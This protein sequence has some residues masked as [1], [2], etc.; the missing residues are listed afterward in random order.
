MILLLL[1][2]SFSFFT[3]RQLWETLCSIYF[4]SQTWYSFWWEWNTNKEA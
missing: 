2:C 4:P 1:L 3:F